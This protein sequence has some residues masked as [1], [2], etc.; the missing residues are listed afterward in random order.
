MAR[1][2]RRSVV[3]VPGADATIGTADAPN[4]RT[5]L[6]AKRSDSIVSGAFL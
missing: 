6:T 4:S 2:R 3:P 5:T 1:N